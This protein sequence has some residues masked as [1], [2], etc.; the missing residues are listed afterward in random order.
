MA[1]NLYIVKYKPEFEKCIE[2]LKH[3]LSGIR[4][5]RA[6]TTLVEEVQVEAYGSHQ[7]IK[8]LAN[9]TVPENNAI[10][11][12]PWDKSVMKNIENALVKASLGLEIVNLGEKILAKVPMLTEETRKEMVKLLGKKVEE[13]RIAVR[14]VRDEVKD[15]I[16]TAEKNKE[17]SED[18]KYQY[19]G[20][21][22][23]YT[24]KMN[25]RI[26]ELRKEKEAELMKV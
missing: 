7:M 15:E 10:A 3:E 9:L 21:L 4:T 6:N 17:I 22:D 11:I 18:D 8:N 20:D 2:F 12:Q 24:K 1:E 26:E 5:G 25:D 23:E 16:T 13:S 14:R 19:L